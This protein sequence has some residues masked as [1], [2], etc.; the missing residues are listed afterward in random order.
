M[1]QR[2]VL[3]LLPFLLL[4]FLLSATA[5]AQTT[6]QSSYDLVLETAAARASDATVIGVIGD[7]ISPDDGTAASW[8]YLME[9]SSTEQLFGLLRIE[10]LVTDPIDI[11]ALPAEVTDMFSPGSLDAPWIDS[12][13][14]VSIAESIGGAAFRARYD[15]ANITAALLGVPTVDVEGVELPPVAALW[16]VVYASLSESAVASSIYVIEGQFGI[17]LDIEPTTAHENLAAAEETGALF[18]DDAELVTVSTLFPDFTSEG[19]ATIWQFTYYSP[20]INESR[21]V[22]MAS[23]LPVA[24]TPA[25]AT[26]VST[27]ALPENWFDSPVAGT[28]NVGLDPSNGIVLSPSLVQARLSRGLDASSPGDTFWQ[29]NYSLIEEDFLEGIVEALIEEGGL[30]DFTLDGFSIASILIPATEEDEQMEVTPSAFTLIDAGS[31]LPIPGFDPIVQDAVLDLSLLPAG[32]NAIAAFEGDIQS[33]TFELNGEVVR[34]ERVAPYALFGDIN[35]N[36]IGGKLPIGKHVL[37][38]IPGNTA[39]APVMVSFEVI[40]SAQPAIAGIVIVDAS[41]NLTAMPLAAGMS[42]AASDLPDQF[43]IAVLTNGFEN[44]VL[45]DLNDG[46]LR[47]LENVEPYTLFGDVQGDYLPGSLPAGS[48]TLTVTPYTEPMAGGEAGTPFTT[49]FTITGS[50]SKSSLTPGS[51]I[52]P[53]LGM[54]ETQPDAFVLHDN[55]PNPFNP[56]TNISFTLPESADIQL[57]VYDVLGREV[58]RLAQGVFNAGL[59]TVTF[60]AGNLPSGTY[61]YNLFTPSGVVVNKMLLVK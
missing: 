21:I 31:D 1:K 22:Y 3:F 12:D 60:E 58:R 36:F 33:V 59:H 13:V 43:N 41:T 25:I 5:Q 28:A 27:V 4:V 19:T 14:A 61:F 47:R 56:Q 24:V 29:L 55:Y 8:L 18:S 15:D 37:K 20:S 6:A 45:L 40:N 30:E 2:S 7:G 35:G 54:D 16:V 32:L 23:G 50:A 48:Y 11:S 9:S 49:S 42:V 57:I 38:A 52:E 34:T 10:D 53:L 17:P 46:F 26:P 44:S 51:S 39:I